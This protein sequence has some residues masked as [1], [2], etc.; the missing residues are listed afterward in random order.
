[1]KNLILF[2][3]VITFVFTSCSSDDDSDTDKVVGAWT[4]DQNFENGEEIE[5]SSCDKQREMVVSAD[6]TYSFNLYSV[7]DG[8][9]DLFE[10]LTGTWE[11]NGDGVYLMHN[12]GD[13]EDD[14]TEILLENKTFKFVIVDGEYTNTYIYIKN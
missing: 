5:L 10:S 11:N 4:Y 1:M 2:F 8:S 3:A 6:G 7:S 13:E 9:C 12:D 14:V